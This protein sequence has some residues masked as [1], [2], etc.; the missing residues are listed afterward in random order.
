MD[1]MET[2][3]L[4][5][6]YFLVSLLWSSMQDTAMMTFTIHLYLNFNRA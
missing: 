2:D 4:I 3:C 6:G 5:T 1:V